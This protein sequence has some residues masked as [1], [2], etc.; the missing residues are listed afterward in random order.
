[1][2]P[3]RMKWRETAAEKGSTLYCSRRLDVLC[4]CE[5]GTNRHFCRKLQCVVISLSIFRYFSSLIPSTSR[6]CCFRRNRPN[7]F[8]CPT[9]RC[10]VSGPIPGRLSSSLT[11]AELRSTAPEMDSSFSTRTGSSVRTHEVQTIGASEMNMIAKIRDTVRNPRTAST[12][13]K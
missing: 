4:P 6:R 10:A 9:I 2:T 11:V 7:F 3:P 5:V 13:Y 1:M 12:V 8:L